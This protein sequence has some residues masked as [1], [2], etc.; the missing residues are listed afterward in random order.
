MELVRE[1]ARKLGWTTVTIASHIDVAAFDPL[2]A[3][4]EGD[5]LILHL[6]ETDGAEDHAVG[7]TLGWIFDSNR[8]H[9][10]PLS[11]AGLAAVNYAGIVSATR[12]TPKPKIAAALAKKRA[13]GATHSTRQEGFVVKRSGENDPGNSP[14]KQCKA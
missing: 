8:T 10:L 9:A 1:T 6:K 11:P 3:C 7:I 5:V 12:L 2:T 13:K 4:A 14:K